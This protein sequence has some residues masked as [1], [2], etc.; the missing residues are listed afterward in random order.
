M[1]REF[2]GQVVVVTGGSRGIGR[3]IVERFAA[4]G[5]KVFFTFHQNAEAAV[6]VTAA[7]QAVAIQCSQTDGDAITAAVEKI[8]SAAGKI[9][10]L[11]NNAG[12]TADTFLMLMPPEDWNRVIDTNLN[13]VYRWCKAVTRPMLGARRGVVINV[14]SI[15]GLVGVMGQ[16]NYAA[17]KGAL[18]AFTRAL[19]AELGGKNIRV[20]SVVPGFVETDMSARV[21]RQI[22]QKNLDHIVQKR[23]G[24]PEEVASVVTFLASDAASYIMGQAIVVDGGLTATAA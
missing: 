15:A 12:I 20:N 18:L 13:G 10:V 2:E 19:A 8:I 7:T 1:N 11:V 3:A 21:P 23:F 16:T 4:Q 17:S 22:K 24:K 6:Q 14:A 9:D 5:A